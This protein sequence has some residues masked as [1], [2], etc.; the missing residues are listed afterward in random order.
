ME[1]KEL[2]IP[3]GVAQT[4][5]ID[6]KFSRGG[7]YAIT[8]HIA[9]HASLTVMGAMQTT[10]PCTVRFTAILEGE[11]ASVIDR[12]RYQGRGDAMLDIERVVVHAAPATSSHMD[13]RGVLYDAARVLWRGRIVVERAAKKARAFQRHDAILA[14]G[15]AEV[16]ASPVLE[17][18]AHD[19]SCKHSASVRRLQ[20]EQLFYMMS[21]GMSEA[22]AREYLLE[23]FLA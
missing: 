4:L 16:D 17:I 23:G 11:G 3:E 2:F 9:K 18:F 19:V 20:P 10:M 12:S 13:A 7:S 15:A 14:S 21:R 6:E 1:T 22:A 5:T 8:A